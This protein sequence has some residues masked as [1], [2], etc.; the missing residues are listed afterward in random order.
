M[1]SPPVKHLAMEYGIPVM[2]PNRLKEPGV[3]EQLREWD[4]DVYV[5]AAFGQIFRK[6]I[7][8]IPKFGLINVHASLL[9]RWRGAAPIQAAILAGDQI[10]GVSIMKIDEGI[11]TG[12]VFSQRSMEILPE[13]TAGELSM[14]L[15]GA[16]ADLLMETLPGILDGQLTG[17]PQVE[18]LATYAG[19]IKKEDGLLNISDPA[20]DICRKIRAYQPWPGAKFV[21]N[22]QPISVHLASCNREIKKQPGIK[23]IING[24]PAVAVN[25]GVV[26]LE[27][28][29][30]PG[31]KSMDGRSFLLGNRSWAEENT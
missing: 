18:N 17:I 4:A 9:P 1:S 28:L 15:A 5:V 10:T 3:I 30:L 20:E 8:E 7:L 14:R 13:D 11:D 25:D 16:G 31:K 22:E 6:N 21:L 12:A 29:Q 27:Q 23:L 26:I 19:M 24:F 2:Q